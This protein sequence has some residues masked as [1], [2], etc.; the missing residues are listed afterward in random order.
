MSTI[1]A[2][3]PG[4]NI[5]RSQHYKY[6]NKYLFLDGNSVPGFILDDQKILLIKENQFEVVKVGVADP[7][8]SIAVVDGLN[9]LALMQTWTDNI[10]VTFYFKSNF[11]AFV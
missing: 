8:A 3:H 1:E 7:A 6:Y 4:I 5:L 10:Q 9:G 2:Q 11:E